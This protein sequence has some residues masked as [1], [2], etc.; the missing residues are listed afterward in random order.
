M[1]VWGTGIFQDDTASDVRDEYKDLLGNGMTGVQATRRIL[2][3]YSSSLAD[4]D[5]SGVVWLALAATQWKVG[6]LEPQ[7]LERALEVI[8]SG[9]DLKRWAAGT[10]DFSKRKVALEKLREQITS[11][12][13]PERKIARRVLCE[14]DWRKGELVAFKLRSGTSLILRVI[15]HHTD[16][17][18]KYP[19]CE[20]L[21]W[22][23]GKLPDKKELENLEIMSSR[24]DYKH[25]IFKIMLVGMNQRA[26]ARLE[27]LDIRLTP[28]QQGDG[29]PFLEFVGILPKRQHPGS[30]VVHWKY[31]DKFFK[32]WFQLE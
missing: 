23:G 21:D 18:G 12:Q 15:D 11:P 13:P 29:I 20:I 30:T 22:V 25:K 27:R 9:A 31:I 7:T 1:G 5:E 26:T 3:S 10:K 14:C 16:R 19:I 32:E 6:R 24:S 8:D 28:A 17:G 4:P 2:E